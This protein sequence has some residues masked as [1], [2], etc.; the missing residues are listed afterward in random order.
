MEKYGNQN[1]D[2]YDVIIHSVRYVFFM[3]IWYCLC[4]L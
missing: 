1:G 4:K 3:Y 2:V